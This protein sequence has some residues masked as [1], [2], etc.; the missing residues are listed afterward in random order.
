[1]TG[2]KQKSEVF[3]MNNT[4]RRRIGEKVTLVLLSVVLLLFLLSS[5]VS[6]QIPGDVNNDGYVDIRDV[7]LVQ[8]YILGQQMLTPTQMTAADVNGDGMVNVVD[9]NLMMQYIQ[10]YINSFPTHHLYA[11]VLIAPVAGAS[12]DGSMVNFQWGAV[13]GAT[14]YQLEISKASDGTIFRTV[15]LGNVTANTQYAFANDGAQY[16][17]RVRA[18][19]STQWGAWS[20]HRTFTNGAALPAPT[21][22]S[23]ANNA[24]LDS[25]SVNFQWSAVT[26]ATRYQLEVVRVS[27]GFVFKNVELGNTTSASQSGFPNDGTEYRWR[28]RAGNAHAWGAWTVYRNFSSGVVLPAPTLSS[29]ANNSAISG[30]SVLFRWNAVSGATKYQLEVLRGTETVP[31]KDVTVGNINM[32]EQFGFLRDGTQYRWRVRAGNNTG[33]GAWSGYFTLTSGQLPVAPVLISPINPLTPAPGRQVSFSWQAVTGAINYELE[34]V[35]ER[36]GAF[37]TKE[38]VGNVTSSVQRGFEDDA[39]TYKWRVRAASSEGWGAWS[40]YATFVNGDKPG[41]PALSRPEANE[42]IGRH[43]VNFEWKPVVGADSYQLKIS[44]GNTVYRTVSVQGRTTSLQQ[45]FPLD[46]SEYTWTVMAGNVNGWG[47]VWATSRTFTVGSPFAMPILITP[48]ANSTQEGEEITFSWRKVDGATIYELEI[49]DFLTGTVFSNTTV[50]PG[51]ES[52]QTKDVDDFDPDLEKQ[53]KWRVRA[54]EILAGGNKWGSWSGYWHFINQDPANPNL[55]APA[56]TSPAEGAVATGTSVY[57]NWT[58]VSGATQ[59]NLQVLYANGSGTQFVY[60]DSIDAT[61]YPPYQQEGFPDDV[62]PFYWRVRA[63]NADGSGRWSFYRHFT[64][65]FWWVLP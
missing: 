10:G 26:G 58:P 5:A 2:R 20:L 19:S 17:W 3:M 38:T 47:E 23:P 46:G 64:N 9:V 63:S 56:L 8:R 41:A 13:T 33:W 45:D 42:N 59:Y 14:R 37:V 11:P 32:S 62:T 52:V 28:V 54:G 49:V 1:M 34:I 50:T 15:D 51:S 12:V 29:P 44:K 7:V 40:N 53:Y 24:A 65:G 6:A 48:A 60:N 31:F 55:S 61:L 25:T 43:W 18:G 57:F 4:Y 21:L 35:K 22:G 30:T 27:D 39:A 16:R 36:T